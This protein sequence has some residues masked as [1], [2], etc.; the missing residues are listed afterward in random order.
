MLIFAE[1]TPQWVDTE[2]GTGAISVPVCHV[3]YF[4]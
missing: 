3:Q 4:H 2:E 1:E